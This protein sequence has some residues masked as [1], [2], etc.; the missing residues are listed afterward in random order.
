MHIV[1]LFESYR[2]IPAAMPFALVSSKSPAST[3]AVYGEPTRQ[4]DSD[5]LV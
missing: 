4:T 1:L 3:L 2:L 5:A